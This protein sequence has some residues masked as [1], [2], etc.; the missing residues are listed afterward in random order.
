[1]GIP[2]E[3]RAMILDHLLCCEEEIIDEP[4]IVSSTR[5][6]LHIEETIHAEEDAP[7]GT[8][9]GC[10]ASNDDSALNQRQ[11]RLCDWT[12]TEC[13]HNQRR[14]LK[15]YQ[16]PEEWNNTYIEHSTIAPGAL[17]TV[18]RSRKKY[19]LYPQILSV[20]GP[21]EVEGIKPLYDRKEIQISYVI[22]PQPGV[23]ARSSV[24]GKE[25]L[26]EALSQYPLIELIPNWKTNHYQVLR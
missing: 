26:A 1:M 12:G 9:S 10:I 4:D 19:K 5:H 8:D 13:Q 15:P 20:C 18:Y 24:V 2:K 3:I 23:K 7:I 17:A 22:D 6:Q 16:R 25:S 21:L 11:Y 14:P